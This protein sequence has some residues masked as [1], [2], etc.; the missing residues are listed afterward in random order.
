MKRA[1]MLGQLVLGL[2]FLFVGSQKLR[3]AEH[4]K[5]SFTRFGYP[6]WLRLLTGVMEVSS[7]AVMLGGLARPCLVPMA[8]AVLGV[9]LSGALSTHARVGDSPRAFIAPAGLLTLVAVVVM[10]RRKCG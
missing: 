2:T 5:A 10:I 1:A 4:M 8:G 3:G 7:G 6:S 9:S